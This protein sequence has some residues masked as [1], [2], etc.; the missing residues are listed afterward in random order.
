[1]K[2]YEH[3]FSAPDFDKVVMP[4]LIRSMRETSNKSKFTIKEIVIRC[5]YS[6][7]THNRE[8]LFE[9]ASYWPKDLQ[10]G[11][12]KY[13][14]LFLSR[15]INLENFNCDKDITHDL[16]INYTTYLSAFKLKGKDHMDEVS[17][18]IKKIKRA[19]VKRRN[20]KVIKV[21][22]DKLNDVLEFISRA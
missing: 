12:S 17:Q 9:N 16:I 22:I 10:E 11:L 20:D 19:L 8:T 15:V 7:E 1:M 18:A 4:I 5:M 2:K 14:A 21:I 13:S 6:R 3:L